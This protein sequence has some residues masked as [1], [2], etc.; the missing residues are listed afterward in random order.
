MRISKHEEYGLRLVAQLA[1]RDDQVAIREMADHEGLPETTVAKVV[2]RLRNAGLV[3]AER[4]RN[5]GYSLVLP[6]HEITLAAVVEA[7]GNGVYDGDFCARMSSGGDC[8]HDRSCGLRPVWHGLGAVIGNFLAGMTVADLVRGDL[9][10]DRF[11]DTTDNLPVVDNC[12]G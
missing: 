9:K 3:T 11:T 10:T 2:A 12:T 6:A 7:F 5:G 8:A 4:G 1:A